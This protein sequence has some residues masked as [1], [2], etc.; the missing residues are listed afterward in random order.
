MKV[1]LSNLMVYISDMPRAIGFYQ[2]V[3]GTPPA[4]QSPGW[5]QWDLGGGISLGLHPMK[6]ERAKPA[7]GWTPSF[8]VVDLKSAGQAAVSAGGTAMGYHD[9][10]GG[11]ILSVLDPDG[12]QMDLQQDGVTCAERGVV[13][14]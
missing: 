3:L 13:S 6:G 5:S 10:P 14:T 1:N 11:V 4:S 9:I 2:T 8:R 7:P 12:N